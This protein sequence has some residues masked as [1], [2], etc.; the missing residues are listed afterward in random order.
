MN[1]LKEGI[2]KLFLSYKWQSTRKIN[3]VPAH[4]APYFQPSQRRVKVV[5]IWA[6]TQEHWG[7]KFG[8]ACGGMVMW[9][10]K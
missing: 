6:Q 2:T 1:T 7:G 3:F 9:P 8:A 4:K 10:I 5:A